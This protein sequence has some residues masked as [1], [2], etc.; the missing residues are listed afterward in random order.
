VDWIDPAE[1][2]ARRALSLLTSGQG[3][4]PSHTEDCAL[5]TSGRADS[6]TRRLMHG[7]GL[8]PL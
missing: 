8:T 4:E 7:F 2:I 5:F 3:V 6:A 1:A